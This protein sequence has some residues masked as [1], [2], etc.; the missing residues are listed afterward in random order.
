MSYGDY[1]EVYAANSVKNNNEERTTSSIALY[2]SSNTQSGWMFMSLST[3]RIL[4]RRQWKRLSINDKIIDR[5][6][7]LGNKEN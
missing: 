4:H 1:A 3:G 5:V 6:E 2:P 7:E